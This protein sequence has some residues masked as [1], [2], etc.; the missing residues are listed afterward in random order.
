MPARSKP[1]GR[2]L[3]LRS[4]ALKTVA[5]LRQ[6]QPK[7][8]APRDTGADLALIALIPYAVAGYR[9]GVVEFTCTRCGTPKAFGLADEDVVLSDLAVWGQDHRCQSATAGVKKGRT[10]P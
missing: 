1:L 9:N 6:S 3:P 10:A 8:A 2:G 5:T 4:S 7:H